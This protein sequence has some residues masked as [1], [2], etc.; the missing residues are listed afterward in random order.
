MIFASGLSGC[1]TNGAPKL[2][3]KTEDDFYFVQL[4]DSHWGFEGAANPDA[5]NTLKKAVVAVNSLAQ[6]P[7]FIIFTGDLTHTT[8]DPIERRK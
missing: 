3:N 2:G 5:Q 7:D 6:Q 8:D 4:S 1:A